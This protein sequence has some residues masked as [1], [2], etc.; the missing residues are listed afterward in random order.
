MS[1]YNFNTVNH[2]GQGY[3]TMGHQGEIAASQI[4]EFHGNIGNLHVQTNWI[5]GFEDFCELKLVR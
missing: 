1:I 3:S 2:G 5:V 4:Q